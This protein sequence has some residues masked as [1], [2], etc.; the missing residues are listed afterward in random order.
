[1]LPTDLI[2]NITKG[3]IDMLTNPII[4]NNESR[5]EDANNLICKALSIDQGVCRLVA[6]DDESLNGL[7]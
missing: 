4:F 2:R 1:M 3:I 5:F 7:S 6:F